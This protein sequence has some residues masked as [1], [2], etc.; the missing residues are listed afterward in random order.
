MLKSELSEA[1]VYANVTVTLCFFCEKTNTLFYL[2]DLNY[3]WITTISMATWQLL[4]A[5]SLVGLPMVDL[6]ILS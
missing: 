1:Y 2:D 4:K 5:H 6:F 3:C